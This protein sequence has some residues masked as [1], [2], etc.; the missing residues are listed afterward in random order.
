MSEAAY[1]VNDLLIAE[2]G[3]KDY[4][5]K[6]NADLADRYGIK[7]DDFPVVKLFVKGKKDPL[8]FSGDFKAEN[9]QKFIRLN[10]GV[11]LQ[12]S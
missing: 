5:D 3:V 1:S 9:I 8:T 4:G 2:V 12:A 10:S 7:K 6:D 11:S